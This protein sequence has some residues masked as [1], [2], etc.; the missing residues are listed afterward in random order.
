MAEHQQAQARVTLRDRVRTAIAARRIIVPGRSL[1]EHLRL[2]EDLERLRPALAAAVVFDVQNVAD[3]F[4]PYADDR[5]WDLSRDFPNLAPPYE[6]CWLEYAMPGEPGHRVGWLFMSE[7]APSYRQRFGL[8]DRPDFRWGVAAVQFD[9]IDAHIGGPTA[10][11]TF[12]V[13]GEG[14]IPADTVP[15]CGVFW[16][17]D[18]MPERV[19]AELAAFPPEQWQVVYG[20]THLRVYLYPALLAI[21]LLHVRNVVVEAHDPPPKFARAYARRNGGA[22]LTTYHT[23]DIRPLQRTVHAHGELERVGLRRSLHLVRGHFADYREG[24]GLFGRHHGVFWMPAHAR[25]A[26]DAGRVEKDYRVHRPPS[27]VTPF[28]GPSP[29]PLD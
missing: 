18:A 5:D 17:L 3:Y 26:R 1:E 25:G 13:T 4:Q 7:D 16:P 21:S 23:L 20:N 11:V 28:D 15:G 29:A 12:P 19:R 8:D 10:S 22:A 27:T 6:T 2:G 14:A 9:Q 24:R